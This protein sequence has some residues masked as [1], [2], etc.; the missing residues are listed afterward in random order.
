MMEKRDASVHSAAEPATAA[1]QSQ[2]YTV[3]GF[4]R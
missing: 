4:N 1:R 3:E 2:T